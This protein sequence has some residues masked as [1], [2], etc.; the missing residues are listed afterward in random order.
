MK[1][2][3]VLAAGLALAAALTVPATAQATTGRIAWQPCARPEL[4]GLDCATL[5]VPVDWSRP[6]AGEISL[7]LARRTAT[8]QAH[9]VGSL[10]L[11]DGAGGSSIEQ[12]RYAVQ[13]G[14]AQSTMAQRFDLVAVD[15]RGIGH[16]DPTGC[17][18]KPQR[19]PG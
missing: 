16:S 4:A 9:R 11:N 15:P 19:G 8:D 13:A 6:R 5:T 7:S 14:I 12:L 18:D 1:I 17:G 2:K 3:A 10:L